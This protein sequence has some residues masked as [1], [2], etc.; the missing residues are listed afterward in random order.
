MPT[1]KLTG[2]LWKLFQICFGAGLSLILL[3]AVLGAVSALLTSNPLRFSPRPAFRPLLFSTAVTF[4]I[5]PV[6]FGFRRHRSCALR[7]HNTF[8]YFIALTSAVAVNFIIWNLSLNLLGK[9]LKMYSGC[10]PIQ[11]VSTHFVGDSIEENG[12]GS[13]YFSLEGNTVSTLQK[14]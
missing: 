5:L 4:S 7:S 8:F 13:I 3:N 2:L 14:A 12:F 11:L 6:S 9:F 1:N 10:F